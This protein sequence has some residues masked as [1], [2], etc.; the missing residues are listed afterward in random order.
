MAMLNLLCL[1]MTCTTLTFQTTTQASFLHPRRRS[2]P[3]LHPLRCQYL[4][5]GS[6]LLAVTGAK[7]QLEGDERKAAQMPC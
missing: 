2:S 5:G 3:R 4:Q 1:R 6:R 7:E